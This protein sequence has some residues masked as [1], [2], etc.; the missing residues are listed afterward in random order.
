MERF[1]CLA[2]GYV[3]GM[4]QTAFIYGKINH[5]DI[6]DYGSG[7]A[8]TTNALRTLGKKAGL[9]TFLGDL[10]KALLASLV[11]RLIYGDSRADCITLLI[12]Y[13]GIGVVLGH[14]FPAYLKFKG[15]KGIAATA[16]VLLSLCS[17]QICVIGLLAFGITV[18]ITKY[19]SA[20]SL[21]MLVAEFAAFALLSK[22][23]LIRGLESGAAEI[24]AALVMF[25]FVVLGFA[26]HHANM[27]RLW[28]GTENALSFKKS[29]KEKN[30][31]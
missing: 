8:G 22:F 27:V 7:N 20:G 13:S 2:I 19:V 12:L 18:A 28:N 17:W 21:V 11:V 10:A 6:R 3:F 30:H 5:I 25:A 16:G 1:I 31:E 4:F 24:E 29:E 15:G 14:N 23:G 9:I 26:R